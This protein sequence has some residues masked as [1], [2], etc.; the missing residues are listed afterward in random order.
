MTSTATAERSA[1][2][3]SEGNATKRPETQRR[4]T[5]LNRGRAELILDN[6]DPSVKH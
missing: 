2:P 6:I 3:Q 5:R 1:V 4:G